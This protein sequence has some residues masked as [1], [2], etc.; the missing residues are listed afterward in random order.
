M[1]TR[2]TG[3][4]LLLN[5]EQQ[6]QIQDKAKNCEPIVFFSRGFV[7]ISRLRGFDQPKKTDSS[8]GD[9]EEVSYPNFFF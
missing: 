6:E 4:S 7:H 2:L 8:S 1:P 5:N 3:I 9:E